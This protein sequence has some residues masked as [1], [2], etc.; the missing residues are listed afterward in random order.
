[1]QCQS[2]SIVRFNTGIEG[3]T[4]PDNRKRCAIFKYCEKAVVAGVG[5]GARRGGRILTRKV[6]ADSCRNEGVC[7]PKLCLISVRTR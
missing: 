7:M 5:R 4:G 1:M 6:Y 3:E 2:E